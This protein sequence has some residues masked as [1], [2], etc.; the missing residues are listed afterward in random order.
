MIM[1]EGQDYELIPDTEGSDNQ[2][3]WNIRILTGEFVET[4]VVFG[5]IGFDGQ[6][7]VLT[8]NYHVVYSPI[9]D[10]TAEDEDLQSVVGDVLASVLEDAKN[11]GGLLAIDKETGESIPLGDGEPA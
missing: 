3:S 11:T 4:V 2:Q 9:E 8:F 7:D 1:R 5:N 10:L 6:R